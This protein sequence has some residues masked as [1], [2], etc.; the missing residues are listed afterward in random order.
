[1]DYS[2]LEC[3]YILEQCY[4]LCSEDD[5]GGFLGAISPEIW[6]DG[7]PIDIAVYHDWQARNKSIK[8]EGKDILRQIYQFLELY[9]KKFGYNFSKTK[10]TLIQDIT[11]DII[12]K[13]QQN[14][15]KIL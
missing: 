13:A 6:E 3:F 12:Q 4:I 8:M 7:K 11:E 14:A 2:F 15:K 9:E 10:K 5:L 1:M